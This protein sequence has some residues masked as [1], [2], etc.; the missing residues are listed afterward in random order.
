MESTLQ[1]FRQEI[2]ARLQHGERVILYGPRGTGKSTLLAHLHRDLIRSGVPCGCSS[3]TCHLDDITQA[4]ARAYPEVKAAASVKRRIARSRLWVAADRHG[5]VLLLDH[6]TSV[7]NA[8]V[9]FMRRLVGGIAGVLLT[10]DVDTERERKLLRAGRLGGM[11]VRM[12]AMPTD[13]LETVWRQQCRQRGLAPPPPKIERRLLRMAAGRPGWIVHCA[14]LAAQNRY[15]RDGRLALV[16]LLCSDTAIALR[17]G[18]QELHRLNASAL[19]QARCGSC[20]EA[21]THP[22]RPLLS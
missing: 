16:N 20:T 21:L 14:E 19:K 12:P 8:M 17:Y 18:M 11:P 22:P 4:L 7:N 3:A 13:R 9:G 10:F 5:G 1:V 15:W 2:L 6:V